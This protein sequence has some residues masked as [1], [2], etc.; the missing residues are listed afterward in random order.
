LNTPLH[1]TPPHP[2]PAYTAQHTAQ[3][4]AQ[5][6]TQHLYAGVRPQRVQHVALIIEREPLQRVRGAK[7]QGGQEGGEELLDAPR[8]A[9]L[10]RGFRVWV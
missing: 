9:D 7:Q 2:T 5:H 10:L 1:P 8:D 4:I 3:H 6:S